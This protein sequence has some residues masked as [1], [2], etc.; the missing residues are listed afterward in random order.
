MY[1]PQDEKP[2]MT[3]TEV[4]NAKQPPFPG[5]GTIAD[6]VD[7]E[8]ALLEAIGYLAQPFPDE[9]LLRTID[10]NAVAGKRETE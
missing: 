6:M 7:R 3:A 10:C 2:N 9:M 1:M 8:I 5:H 4:Q